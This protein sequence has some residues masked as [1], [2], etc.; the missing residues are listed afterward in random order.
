MTTISLKEGW[1]VI[2]VTCPKKAR[3]ILAYLKKLPPKHMVAL[4]FETTG[5]FPE[6]RGLKQH[7]G[8]RVR[9]TNLSWEDGK[10]YVLDHD[11]CGSFYSLVDDIIEARPEYYVFHAPFETRWF[12]AFCD[13]VKVKI[14]DVANMRK[15]VQGGGPL[16]LKIMAK[17]DLDYTMEKEEQLSDWSAERLSIKQFSYAGRDAIITKQLADLWN[18]QM[19]NG[20]WEGCHIINDCVRSVN[21][22]ETTGMK[23]DVP[24]HRELIE[25]WGK[26]RAVA[27]VVLNKY[28]PPGLIANIRSKKQLSEFLKTQLDKEAVAAWPKTEKTKQL[29]TSRAILKQASFRAPYPF[30]RWLAAL[31]VFNRADKYLSTYGEKLITAQKLSGRVFSRF[32]IAQAITGRFSSSGGFNNQNY[33][34]NPKVR[35]SF[36]AGEGFKLVVADYSGVELRVLAEIS[37]DEQLKQDVIFGNMHAESAIT[38]HGYDHDNF[39]AALDRKEAWAVSQRSKAK[40]FSFQLCYGAGN[41]ALALVMRCTDDEA[42]SHVRAWAKRYPKAYGYRQYMFE[43]MRSTGYLP[44]VSGR[45]IYVKR[46]DR[47]M[48]VASNYPIQSAAADVMYRACTRVYDLLEHHGPAAWIQATIHD[49]LVLMA[50]TAHT[51]KAAKLLAEGM[52]NAW[53]DIFPGTSIDNLVEVGVGDN[54]A[55]A[56]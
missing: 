47:T 24:Y 25:M 8:A 44:V 42:G 36:I 23:L 51:E 1:K 43:K 26:R 10:A 6:E 38:L 21:E 28:T 34:N 29:Q 53:L 2:P 37:G 33:P 54:W 39:M 40:A 3:R 55:E 49:E 18:K 17:W 22:M 50:E 9:T 4:D 13:E 35:K 56:K 5:L 27:Q 48:P 41:A 52:K 12:D 31:M 16:S 19:V 11:Y 45:T 32:N 14:I 20:H 30:S 46:S 7:M 15:A